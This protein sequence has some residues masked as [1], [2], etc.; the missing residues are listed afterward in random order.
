[1]GQHHPAAALVTSHIERLR[2]LIEEQYQS[3]PT[4]CGGSFGELLCY[5]LHSGGLTFVEIAEKWSMG[6]PTLGMLI[7]DHCNRMEEE[8]KVEW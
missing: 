5:E 8:P 7:A 1:M 6:L 3:N 4:G 2:H